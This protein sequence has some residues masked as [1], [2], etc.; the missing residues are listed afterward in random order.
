MIY[1]YT[2][3]GKDDYGQIKINYYRT[4]GEIYAKIIKKDDINDI[5]SLN[6]E[7]F[8][9]EE[10]LKKDNAFK[11]ILINKEDTRDCYGKGCYLLIS[12]RQNIQGPIV[13]E[14]I[15][16]KFNIGVII[17]NDNNK[18]PK[19]YLPLNELIMGN[20]LPSIDNDYYYDYYKIKIPYKSKEL[21]FDFQAYKGFIIINIGKSN[22]TKDN[23][24]FIF[25][26]INDNSLFKLDINDIISK[27]KEK[28]IDIN[29]S[30][31]EL[32]VGIYFVDSS[33]IAPGIYIFKYH[34][35]LNKDLDSYPILSNQK[36]L[37][38]PQKIS[39]NKYRCL[40]FVYLF[41]NEGQNLNYILLYANLKNSSEKAEIY[42]SFYSKNMV[43]VYDSQLIK[44][45]PN[46][47]NADHNE[48]NR[49]NYIAVN[50]LEQDSDL[51]LNIITKSEEDIELLTGLYNYT[52]I[53]P[54]PHMTQLYIVNNND[55][56]IEFPSNENLVIKIIS[57]N[58]KGY[59]Y[60]KNNPGQIFKINGPDNHLTFY[61]GS[62]VKNSILVIKNTNPNIINSSHDVIFYLTYYFVNTNSNIVEQK[63]CIQYNYDY[64]QGKLPFYFFSKISSLEKDLSILIKFNENLITDFSE[65]NVSISITNL[66]D[67]YNNLNSFEKIF[68]SN[69]VDIYSN[70][71]YDPIFKSIYF[72]ISKN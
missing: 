55:L 56:E 10:Y 23:Y 38:K 34:I 8:P 40:V 15:F 5:S 42:A 61:H 50:T 46:Y 65:L 27:A 48:F 28:L 67:I 2:D 51:F 18:Y 39:D 57:V 58:G 54:T 6:Y 53:S 44:N 29:T 64:S 47:L 52:F 59:L 60:W 45:I 36:A 66:S 14:I 9:K 20:I 30:N 19:F 62:Q 71:S 24:H 49:N 7:K 25:K 72:F 32:C 70:Y 16:F 11:Y 33:Y 68:K 63:M 13:P 22:P 1:Y 12:I 35:I 17:K 43:E 3:L 37:C 26:S 4:S 31:I 69:N 41:G 21:I